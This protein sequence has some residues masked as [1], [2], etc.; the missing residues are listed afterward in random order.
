MLVVMHDGDAQLTFQSFFYLKTFRSFHILQVDAAESRSDGFYD[1]DKLLG[2]LF[3]DFDIEY[4]DSRKYLKQ[5]TLSFHYRLSRHGADVAQSQDGGAIG[6]HR[7]QVAFRSIFIRFIRI[8]FDFQTRLRHAGR[9]SERKIPL[10]TIGLGR[11]DLYFSGF[12]GG[13]V[14]KGFFS[15][16][17]CHIEE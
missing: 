2:I 12:A 4:V 14:E 3:I 8:F 17:F 13:M 5:Q 6:Y 11:H 7:H 9:I 1:F 16:Y 15:C 10:R